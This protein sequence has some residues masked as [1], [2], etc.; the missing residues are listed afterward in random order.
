MKYEVEQKFSAVDLSKLQR[1]L[2]EFQATEGET[3]TQVDEYF[4][5]PA[6]DFALTDEALRIRRV[7][8][9]NFVTYKG[10]KLDAATKTRREL[11]L[12][13]SPGQSGAQSFAELLQALG[14]KPVATVGKS[15]R[16]LSLAWEGKD[17]EVAIDE[18][19]GV[20]SFV[21]LEL[22]ADESALAAARASLA[23]LAAALELQGS[24]RRSYLELLLQATQRADK[25]D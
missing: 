13:L 21:E 3:V 5:H 19:A 17:F 10:P 6:R 11:E 4:A 25:K 24:E 14:F 15:R 22:M 7:G 23:S 8:E 20:G 16:Q 2:A 1:K 12:P 18:V 9:E